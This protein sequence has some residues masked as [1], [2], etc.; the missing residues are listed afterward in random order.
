VAHYFYD[1][2]AQIFKVISKTSYE[3][4]QQVSSPLC[5]PVRTHSLWRLVVDRYLR[6][7]VRVR[8]CVCVCVVA[9][10]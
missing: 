10:C 4:G 9:R 3:P 8:W 5:F 7:V 6:G 2:D 1:A